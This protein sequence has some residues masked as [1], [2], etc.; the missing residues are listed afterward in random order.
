MIE[1]KNICKIYNEKI[2]L[3]DINISFEEGKSYAFTGHNGCGKSTLLKIISG[4]IKPSKGNIR[5]DKKL[6]FVYVPEKFKP[7]LLTGRTYLT[8]MGEIDGLSK[9]EINDRIEELA[10]DFFMSE[11]LDISMQSMSKGTLQKIGVIQAIMTKQDVILLDEPLSGQDVASQKVFV[12][13]I[14]RL[15]EEGIT[16]FMS[17]HEKWIV[18]AISDMVYEIKNGSISE[19]DINNKTTYNLIV[20]NTDDQPLWDNMRLFGKNYM[21]NVSNEESNKV[22]NQ[23]LCQGFTLKGMYDEDNISGKI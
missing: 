13:K 21:I 9:K 10:N 16:V 6:S 1:L 23:L 4:I 5:F 17:C 20:E 19:I 2:V 18:N 22:I 12:D 8:R 15:R 11:M 7:I 3:N 14:N